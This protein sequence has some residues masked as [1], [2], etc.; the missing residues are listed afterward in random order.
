MKLAATIK[1][2]IQCYCVIYNKEKR[3]TTQTALD[4]FFNRVHRIEYIKDLEPVPST[5]GVNEIAA[6]STD[7]SFLGSKITADDDCNHEIKRCLLFGREVRT[8][9]DSILKSGEC[10]VYHEKRWAGGSTSWNQDCLEK[11]Q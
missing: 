3:A 11:Y 6:C 4:H 9:L 2:V 1:D 5:T 7:F 8:N 10:R